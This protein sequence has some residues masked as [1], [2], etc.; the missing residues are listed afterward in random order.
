MDVLSDVLN[1]MRI[2]AAQV[3]QAELVPPWGLAIDPVAEAHVHVVQRGRAWL[4]LAGEHGRAHGDIRLEAGDVTLLRGGV[5]HAIVDHPKTPPEPHERVLASMPRRL[6]AWRETPRKGSRETT[7]VL[8][9]KYAL[10]T[11]GPHPLTASLPPLVHLRAEHAH[12]D[13]RLQLLLGLLR[14]ETLA[15]GSGSELVVPRL[16]DT[17]LVLVVRAWLA[18]ASAGTGWFGALRDP[19]ITRALTLLHEHPS[20]AWSVERLAKKVGQSRATFARR[21]ADLVGEPPVAYLTRWRMC[22]ATKLLS[23]T[24]LSLEHIAERV[25]YESGAALSKAFRRSRGQSPGRYRTSRRPVATG[26]A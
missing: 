12:R 16:V 26:R 1:V 5:G 25:G 3:A 20:E 11:A 7:V 8:C 23:E 21:F 4:R 10:D 19:A 18:S 13:E 14:H 24:D 2:G 9:A 15:P 6:A 17:L 22:V